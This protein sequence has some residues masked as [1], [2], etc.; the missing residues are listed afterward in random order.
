[1]VLAAQRQPEGARVWS[2]TTGGVRRRSPGQHRSKVPLLSG[3]QREGW[4]Y[5]CSRLP[6]LLAPASTGSRRG[7]GLSRLACSGHH[8]GSPGPDTS[9]SPTCRCGVEITAEPQGLCDL[10]SRAE[11]SRHGCAK[12]G[13]T[14]PRP[15]L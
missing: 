2:A 3:M 5:H 8:L 9:G 12:H 11:I 1:M 15:A 13:F 7:S 6:H 10:G 4:G 14:P